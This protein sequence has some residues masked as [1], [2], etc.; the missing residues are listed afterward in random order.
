MQNPTQL[1]TDGD[2]NQPPCTSQ[3]GLLRTDQAVDGGSLCKT[4][5][6]VVLKR[7]GHLTGIKA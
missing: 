7:F 6:V 5:K 2:R 1:E 4:S 3:C